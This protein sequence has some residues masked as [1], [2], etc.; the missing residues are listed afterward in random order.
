[1]Q[2][3][4]S[5]TAYQVRPASPRIGAEI[6]GVDLTQTGSIT[7]PKRRGPLDGSPT[8]ETWARPLGAVE[9][10]QVRA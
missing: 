4:T 7:R 1:M 5:S 6:T 9:C 8:F 2:P 10:G 3:T